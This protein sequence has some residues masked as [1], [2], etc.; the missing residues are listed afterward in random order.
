MK[1]IFII[2]I[3]VTAITN[4]MAQDMGNE[5]PPATAIDIYAKIEIKSLNAVSSVLWENKIYIC[6]N[7]GTVACYDTTG[8]MI[9]KH[10]ISAEIVTG[11]LVTD[12][13]IAI[14]TANGEIVSLIAHNGEQI[15]S[16]GLD[17]TL[18]TDLTEMQYE[19]DKE[20]FL[21]KQ[22]TSKT[23]ILF[24]A[25]P[26]TIYCIDLETLQEYWRNKD[27]RGK[28]IYPP[29][30]IQNKVLFASTD[31]YLYCIDA[32][33][34]LLNWRWKETET[35][36]FSEAKIVCDGKKVF[37]VSKDSQ[38]YCIDFLLGTLIWKSEKPKIL[39]SIGLSN[40][41]KNLFA[42]SEDKR[43]LFFSAE[44]GTIIRQLKHDVSFDSSRT[45]PVEYQDKI[46]FTNNGCIYALDKKLKEEKIFDFGETSIIS[47]IQAGNNKFLAATSSGTILIFGIR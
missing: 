29:L 5:N 47:F 39:T 8:K 7:S 38:L 14:G 18:T 17:D 11:P 40:D 25:T 24:G 32:R 37:A 19:G 26:G 20:L 28:I 4:S 35:T 1:K 9:W 44:K 22:S 3:I 45:Q 30:V 27:S 13:Q 21:P 15:Q 43:F 6:E 16:I 23:A 31:G 36:D 2:I 42:K 33:N 12:G 34:G 41:S 46:Y 10:N